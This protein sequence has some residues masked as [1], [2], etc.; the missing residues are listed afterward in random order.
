M[1]MT[2]RER[3]FAAWNGEPSDHIPLTT[4][5]FGFS[6]PEY[7]RWERD[8]REVRYWYSMRLEHIHTL[9]QPWTLED[10]FKRVLAW[11]SLGVDDILDVSVPWSTDREV[12]WEDTVIPAGEQER[13]PVAVREY[14]TPSGPLRHAVKQTGEEPEGWVIQPE[15][16]PLFED[17]NIPRAAEHLVAGP[18]DVAA[19]RHLFTPPDEEAC[20]QFVERMARVK[21]FA[22][23]NDVPVQAWSAFGMDGVV[24]LMGAE[25]AV[26]MAMLQPES[27]GKLMDIVF[28]T[29][30][31]RTELA[32]TT[33]G[34]DMVVQRG[35]Y[36]STDFWSP[37]LFHAHVYPHLQEMTA[38]AHR[39]G[40]KFCYVMTTG[41]ETLGP[42]L[43][44]AGVDVMY[45]VDPMQD[46]ADVVRV[47]ELLGD[48]MT[49]VGGLN[50]VS[51]TSPDRAGIR[52]EV[53]RACEALGPTN[54]FI[55]HPGDALSP[56]TP[57][58]GVEAML[59][60][61]REWR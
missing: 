27:F 20:E 42:A 36:S 53:R 32:V 34:V 23:E 16:V 47:G 7:L 8:G 22:D 6:P 33:P 39:H 59:E 50:A 10:D 46:G 26:M 29:D 40:V 48:R 51:L 1:A 61:W 31:A 13:Y 54:R 18:D 41:V 4:W 55:L 17:L 38:L 25:N 57:W 3:I 60:A 49:L 37:D 58:E 2:C 11:R 24:W 12:S 44:E 35:W 15:H 45:F 56:D 21:A 19:V 30:Y 28:A 43:A 14:Q 5:S 9:P 52:E